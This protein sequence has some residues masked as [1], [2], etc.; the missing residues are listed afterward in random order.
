MKT[1]QNLVYLIKLPINNKL[2]RILKTKKKRELYLNLK[3]NQ[4]N[5]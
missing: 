5:G 3:L 4:T 2:E 1:Y